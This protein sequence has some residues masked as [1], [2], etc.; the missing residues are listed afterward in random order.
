MVLK[1]LSR[2]RFTRVLKRQKM[3]STWRGVFAVFILI[4]TGI[5]F[6]S[7]ESPPE[8][9]GEIEK[10]SI[11][12]SKSFLSIPIYLAKEQGF[13]ASEGLDITIDEYGSG[14][15]ATDAMLRGEVNI[16]TQD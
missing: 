15:L 7:C 1:N 11:G 14:K 4:V 12:I 8:P 6:T 10:I 5:F 3:F 13:F 2:N 16:S 9:V